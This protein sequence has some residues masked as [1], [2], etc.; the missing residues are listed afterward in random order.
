LAAAGHG[1]SFVVQLFLAEGSENF[2]NTATYSWD[3]VNAPCGQ[4]RF[5]GPRDCPADY[6]V[7]VLLVNSIRSTIGHLFGQRLLAS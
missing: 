1:E 2:V 3:D 7:D 4:Q 5:K 6:G